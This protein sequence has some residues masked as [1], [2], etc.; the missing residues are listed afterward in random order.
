[1]SVTVKS[2]KKENDSLKN[3]IEV[4]TKDFKNLEEGLTK[5]FH[6]QQKSTTGNGREPAVN[7][8]TEKHLDI[9]S[10]SYD[11]L[12]RFKADAISQLQQ[13]QKSRL[14]VEVEAIA[15]AIEE[16]QRYNYRY[17]VKITGIPD[18]KPSESAIET[19]AI[20]VK[21]FKK[22]GIEVSER[23]IHIA[24][25]VPTRNTRVGPNL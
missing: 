1:M 6:Q 16:S 20:C 15:S 17:N 9:Y 4:L 19:T 8:E 7:A 10:K 24:H 25:R 3:Q 23:D 18:R 2:L 14:N 22:L 5:K 21:L 11:D 13:Q 12:S